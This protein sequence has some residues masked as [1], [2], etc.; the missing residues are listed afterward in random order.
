MKS[1]M[2]ALFIGHGS[3][4]NTIENNQ[5]RQSWQALGKTLPTAK[6]ILCIS[7]HWETLGVSITSSLVPNTIHDFYGFPKALFDIQY[8][9]PG[10]PELAQQIADMLGANSVHLDG[11]RGLD[12]GAWSVLQPMYPAANIP[13]LQL[14]L[15]RTRNAASHYEL[16]KK[17][18]P[19]REQ[20]VLIIGS[21][22]IAHNLRV[23]DFNEPRPYDWASAFDQTVMNCILQ[24]D[25]AALC[26]YAK[27]GQMATLSIP[28]AEHYL[29]MLYVLALQET[30]DHLKFFNE[31]VMSS[32][33]M[34]SFQIG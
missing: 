9:A 31:E 24:K 26:D 34:R 22:N 16:A 17:L 32:I 28:T 23:F 7:A 2:P 13:V 20:G 12:H 33:S 6:A 3:P 8:P 10:D 15:D 25:H 21:G 30:D 5:F 1:V 14:S 19:L 27:F 18:R 29:P 11:E 4:M